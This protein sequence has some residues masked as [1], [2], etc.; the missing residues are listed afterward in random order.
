M[1]SG[2]IAN[3]KGKGDLVGDAKKWS[4][5]HRA[6]EN[7]FQPGVSVPDNRNKPLMPVCIC[8]FIFHQ[9]LIL[10]LIV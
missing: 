6:L 7:T 5:K 8:L 2:V 1:A 10:Q 9:V 4:G 3:K